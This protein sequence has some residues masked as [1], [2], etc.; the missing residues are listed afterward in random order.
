MRHISFP[1]GETVPSLGQGTYGLGEDRNRRAEQTATLREG[2]A[3]GLGL[4]DTAEMYGSGAT[5][6]F[7][8]EALA[9][10]RDQVFLVSKAS[11]Q[12][13]GQARLPQACEHSLRRLNTD[14]IDLYLLHWRGK[15]PLAETVLAMQALQ[16]AGKIRNWGV[17][18]LDID[19]MEELDRSGGRDCA[20]NQ[21]LYNLQHRGPEFDL[22]PWMTSRSI[23]V[24]AYSP[25]DQGRL[26]RTPALEKIGDRLGL[27]PAQV[28]LAWVLHQT[29]VIAIPKAAQIEHV[30]QNRQA[31]D[32]TLSPSDLAELDQIFQP[33]RRKLPLE[34]L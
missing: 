19:D 23:P 18:N 25:V 21:I 1:G 24:M 17:S 7:L 16:K 9:G 10:L 33:P 2:V 30:R 26:A 4:I 27:F 28:A 3:L 11:P 14:R 34:M 12:N 32:I 8:A 6:R 22:I 5:E 31:L 15:I 20:T 29:R 13:A